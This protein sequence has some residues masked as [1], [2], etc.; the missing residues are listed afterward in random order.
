M[1]VMKS[2]IA[3]NGGIQYVD[4]DFIIGSLSLVIWTITLITT[5]KHVL[6]A[7]KADNRGEG[8]IFALFSLV[9]NHAK[10]LL[11]PAM[12]GGATLLADS[13]LT[14][15]VTVT[16]AI[17]GLKSLPVIDG[18]IW[19]DQR[20]VIL[21]FL[22]II[23][24]LFWIQRAGTS[25]IG[26]LFGPFMMVW[27]LFLGCVGLA[28]VFDDPEVL[29]AFNPIY[30]V[31]VLLS[32]NNKVG[33]MILGS[34]FLATT[35]AEALYSDMG[36]VGKSSI[37]IS[38]PFVK[39]CLIL[40]YLGQGAWIVANTSDESLFFVPDLNP[41][42]LMLSPEGRILGIILGTMAAVIASQALITGSFS[43]VSK[44][45]KLDLLPHMKTFY[46]SDTKGQLYIPLVNKL[47]WVGCSIVVLLFWTSAK[48]ETAY[49]IAITITLLT[50][51]ILLTAY[52]WYEKKK[53]F[54]AIIFALV[55][56]F[57]E[58][59]FF[60]SCIGKFFHGGFVAIIIA[61]LIFA[62]MV[63][64]DRG[65][66][67]EASQRKVL[68]IRNYLGKL[69]HL[70]N[71]N[72]IPL[73]ASNLVF[74][75]S[76]NNKNKIE[77]DIMFSILDKHPKKAKVYWFVHFHVTSKPF[78]GSYSV[79]KF[80][81]DFVYKVNIRLGYKEDQRLSTFMLQIFND[82]L[83][84]NELKPQVARHTIYTD[85]E[86]RYLKTIRPVNIGSVKYC[87]IR[88]TLIPES[89]LSTLDKYAVSGKYRIRSIAGS[90]ERLYG[91][92][93][94]SV[95]IEYVPLFIESK[96]VSTPLKRRH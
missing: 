74:L 80:G 8:G 75:T 31:Q 58:M 61:F 79:E 52:L 26:K 34:V 46:P 24:G 43:V 20:T 54:L 85:E 93:T 56:T 70:K 49:G 83:T 36:H 9:K 29:K 62:V 87:M 10:W 60:V 18:T 15:A 96:P 19:D 13:I 35:G 21:V 47:L 57:I 6:I 14:P 2:I 4:R 65:T 77:R 71:D 91:L 33:I 16:T 5:V 64:W 28:Y 95:I 30:A 23:T 17:E 94:S 67:V 22:L 25:I 27:F 92:E 66:A 82:L 63:C 90:S 76:C 53:R 40:N 86:R 39:L 88:K 59:V 84:A 73:T 69:E 7:M 12:I 37:Y 32:P 45:I 68:D 89:D 72:S 42:Y 41:F 48:M 38:W 44:A 81:T 51:T 50:V 1:Y 78:G 55:Y 3:G 11:I